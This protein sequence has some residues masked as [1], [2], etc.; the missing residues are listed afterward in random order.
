MNWNALILFNVQHSHLSVS[1]NNGL[2]ST[3]CTESHQTNQ[4]HFAIDRQYRQKTCKWK[5]YL[6]LPKIQQNSCRGDT[7]G[8]K[9]PAANAIYTLRDIRPYDEE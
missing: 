2:F 3:L 4:P 1:Y 6:S 7:N 9:D 8:K 5:G